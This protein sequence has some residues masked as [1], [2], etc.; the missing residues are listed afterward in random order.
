MRP[1][2]FDIQKIIDHCAGTM[3]ETLQSGLDYYYPEMKEDE[4]TEE[5][6]FS[7][8]NQ[9]FWCEHCGWCCETSEA[10]DNPQGGSEVCDD[11]LDELNEQIAEE[12]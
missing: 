4:L 6:W 3:E 9:I 8:N 7:I 1:T 11:C 2:D 12:E 10:N 5:D